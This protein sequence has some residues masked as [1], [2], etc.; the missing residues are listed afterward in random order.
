MGVGDPHRWPA[1][2]ILLTGEDVFRR[3][4]TVTKPILRTPPL[5][6]SLALVSMAVGSTVL[7]G[8]TTLA[9]V[10]V[11]IGIGL[12]ASWILALLLLCWAGIEAMAALERW[13]END[14]RFQR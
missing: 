11:L 6:T 8:I 10:P 14:P 13:F 5:V 12:V 1:E 2:E 7:I 9:M 3:D 4:V